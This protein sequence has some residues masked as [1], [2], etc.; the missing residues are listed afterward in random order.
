MI[1]EWLG[2]YKPTN[3][4]EALQALPLSAVSVEQLAFMEE[5]R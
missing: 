2:S 5:L 4:D 1:K 3:K